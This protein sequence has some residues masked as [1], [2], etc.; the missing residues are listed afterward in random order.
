MQLMRSAPDGAL[1]DAQGFMRLAQTNAA[2][3]AQMPPEMARAIRQGDAEGL[4]HIFRRVQSMVPSAPLD[5]GACLRK[6]GLLGSN[7]LHT[8]T[9]HCAPCGSRQDTGAWP[10]HKWC[11]LRR[12][13]LRR[14]QVVQAIHGQLAPCGVDEPAAHPF[15]ALG[16]GR[17][18]RTSWRWRGN[19]RRR[20]SCWPRTPL[21]WRRRPRSR[22]ASARR[23][24]A[25]AFLWRCLM[26]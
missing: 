1:L 14:E 5:G 10:V 23:R 6:A 9:T 3:L 4:Q 15:V 2:L 18:M 8:C 22:S 20:W 16:P 13:P 26:L 19:A 24:R 21:T 11:W 17:C 12:Q 7:S 25:P